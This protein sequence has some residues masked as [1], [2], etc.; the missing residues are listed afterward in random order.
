MSRSDC[1]TRLSAN[2]LIV[3][4]LKSNTSGF[5]FPTPSIFVSRNHPRMPFRCRSPLRT[6]NH[7]ILANARLTTFQELMISSVKDLHGLSSSLKTF[8]AILSKP[9]S[10]SQQRKI[11]YGS[12]LVRLRLKLGRSSQKIRRTL[13]II[14]RATS[15]IL[16]LRLSRH[17]LHA[18][19]SLC[20]IRQVLA[21]AFPVQLRSRIVRLRYRIVH[22]RFRT[23]HLSRVRRSHGQRSPTY[24]SLARILLILTASMH[25]LTSLSK[26]SSSGRPLRTASVQILD[27]NLQV[28]HQQ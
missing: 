6:R 7:L 19:P 17:F 14:P 20:L 24:T 5:F 26:T 4:V 1:L 23:V 22:L 15:S 10:T 3:S 25:K 28:V 11:K 2:I 12:I 13:V 18:H 16:F 21:R 27:G 9:R 8:H